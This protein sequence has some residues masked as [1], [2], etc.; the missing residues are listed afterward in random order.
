MLLYEDALT[1]VLQ[2]TIPP[3]PQEV[4]L[5][6][7][8]HLFLYKD[9]YTT[10]PHPPW[11]NSAMDGYAIRHEDLKAT[12]NFVIIDEIA[13][14]SAPQKMIQSGTCARIF[15]GAPMP[16]GADTVIIQENVEKIENEMNVLTPP[17]FGA[18]V[19]QKG[20]E[21]PPNAQIA[22]ENTRVTIG[23]IGLVAALGIDTLPVYRRPK[24]A[25]LSTG[26]ELVAID[27]AKGLLPGQIWSSNNH[28]LRAAIV[29]AGGIPLDFGIVGDRVEDTVSRLQDMVAAQPDIIITTGGVSVGDHDRVQESL[30]AVGGNIDFWKVRLK[31]GK[32]LAM[33]DIQGIPFFGLPGNPVSSIVS[34]WLFLYPLIKKAMGDPQIYLPRAQGILQKDIKKR[35]R[36]AEFVRVR[37]DKKTNTIVSTGNQS[38][39][40]ISSVALADALLYIPAESEGFSAGQTVDIMLIP[41]G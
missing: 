11:R 25:I 6:E 19:R 21:F 34:F 5:H 7:A 40:W 36:R 17:K 18:N 3:S 30:L 8:L 26:E 29:E 32:P 39:A 27:Q 4:P 13:A 1:R 12:K 16:E 33:G 9:I 10:H 22:S 38:S 28:T 41:K 35:H 31:P 20:E 23:L 37:I 2:K 14:G 24:V 15:T